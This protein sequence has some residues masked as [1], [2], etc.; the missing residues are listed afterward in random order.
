MAQLFS[1]GHMQIAGSK[2]GVC[3][4]NVVLATEGKFCD[5]CGIVV[6]RDCHTK[7]TCEL[8][9]C[10]FQEFERPN[11]DPIQDAILPRALR[12]PKSGGPLFVVG[13]IL[14]VLVLAFLLW[15]FIAIFFGGMHDSI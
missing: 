12:A 14:I 7:E 3:K 8:C 1:L 5:H 2:C 4:Q 9:G 10:A 15:I 6:H 13:L 11:I